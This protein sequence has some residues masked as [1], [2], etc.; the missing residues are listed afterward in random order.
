MSSFLTPPK[1][2]P[3]GRPPVKPRFAKPNPVRAMR[4]REERRAAAAH[5][6]S[7]NLRV[8]AVNRNAALARPNRPQCP[9]KACPK[10]NV[11][12]GTCQTCGRISD[13]SNIVAEVTFG[14]SSSGAAVVHGSFIG[15]DQAGVRSMGPAFR[16]VGGS[17]D[18]EKSIREAKGL[19]QGYAQQLNVSDSLVTAGTQVFKLA[20][21]ANFIQGRTLASVAAVCLYA[22]CRAEPPCKVMLID[23]ADLVQL[24]VFKLGRIFKKLNEVVPIGNDGLIPVYP[25]DLIWRFATKME[26]HQDTAKVAEDAVRLVKRMS[27]D[28]MVMGRRPSGICGACL[29][30]A[31][32]MHNFR[33]TV[34][35]VVYIVKVTNHTIQNRLQ[36]FKV[37]ESSRMSVEDFLK[38][39]FL[40]SSHDPPSFYKQ[41]AEYKKQLAVKNKKRKRLSTDEEAEANDEDD[42]LAD[43]IDPRL[44]EGGADLSKAPVY[45]YRRDDDGFIIPPLPSKIAK[46]PSL[47]SRLSENAQDEENDGE[48]EEE[49]HV[50]GLDSLVEEFGD[51]LE[52]EMAEDGTQD[53]RTRKGDKPQLPINEEWE[54]DEQEL[55]GVIEE[56]FNDPLTYEHAM[57]YTTAEQR[58]RIHTVWALQQRPQKEVSMSADVTEDEF[59]DDPEVNNCLL[60]PEEAQIKEMI[61]V[62]QN[63]EWLRK[64]QEKVF[65]KKVEAERPKQ[66]RKRRK[67]ARMGEGQTSPASSAAEAAVNVAKDRAWSKRINYDAIRNIFDLPNIDGPGSEATSRKTSAAGSTRGGEDIAEAPE[68]SVAGD[69]A[70]APQEDEEE[71]YEEEEEYDE[72]QNYNDGDEF[73]GGNEE[74]GG[75]GY[76]EDDPEMD[77]EYGLEEYA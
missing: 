39:D 59:A 6:Q 41:T 31:A 46:D 72:T 65:R 50:V 34:R 11:V 26:F 73:G 64:H 55:E 1:S 27:R 66:T 23:L 77:A 71:I 62:N 49:N 35:E 20:S 32:R 57:A 51:A 19:M 7:N 58:A 10:P 38:Q 13:D 45:E 56:I 5:T 54:Q 14:E 68:E 15:A 9:N 42:N 67:R 60:S 4:E 43:R 3:S 52:E 70:E 61:W 36:E 40:E 75:G 16:R 24:N 28:W 63:K 29:L 48:E 69:E 12:D 33:R 47:V 21:S 2:G 76:D 30:M 53:T 22:A 74:F 17:E 44:I 18:R 37:T 25:E 8:A